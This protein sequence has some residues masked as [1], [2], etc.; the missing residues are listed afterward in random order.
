MKKTF[1]LQNLGCANCAAKMES[2][3][4]K[5]EGVIDASINFMASRLTIEAEE[6]AFEKILPNAQAICRKIESRCKIEL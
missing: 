5:L 6:G 3:I 1:K 2:G 4:K